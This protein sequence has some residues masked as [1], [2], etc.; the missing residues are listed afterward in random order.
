[1][2]ISSATFTAQII[3][4]ESNQALEPMGAVEE[5]VAPAAQR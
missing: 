3:G 4:G 5:L 2:V 1:M